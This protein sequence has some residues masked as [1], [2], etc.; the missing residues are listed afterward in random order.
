MIYLNEAMVIE[1]RALDAYVEQ[2][3]KELVPLM[4]RHGA[5]PLGLWQTWRTNELIAFW[6]IE[7]YA[8]LDRLDH[9]ARADADLVAYTRSACESR[10][11][12]TTRILGPTPFCPDLAR[13]RAERIK[14]GVYMLAVIPLFPERMA[15]YLELFP[16]HGLRLEE[17][18]GLRTVGYWRGGGGE[19]YQ[20][21]AFTFTQLC[22]G[23]SWAFWQ[24]FFE[25]RARDPE[26]EAWMKR[27]YAYRTHHQVSYLVP[28]YLPY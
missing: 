3:S 20:T 19:P 22:A 10:L 11:R 24:E 7:S 5:Q 1:P 23:E 8:A 13:I 16:Q 15:E 26:V 17:R 21:E 25:R 6:E 27:S 2:F 28:A 12:W 4:D 18:H 14:G 9:A